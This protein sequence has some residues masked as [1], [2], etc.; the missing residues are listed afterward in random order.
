MYFVTFNFDRRSAMY[1]DINGIA[2][3]CANNMSIWTQN[4]VGI[5]TY[6]VVCEFTLD[7]VSSVVCQSKDPDKVMDYLKEYFPEEFI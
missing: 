4:P 5:I 7:N 2:R 6:S 1:S 3:W